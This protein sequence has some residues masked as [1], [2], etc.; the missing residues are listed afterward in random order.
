MGVVDPGSRLVAPEGVRRAVGRLVGE[1][2]LERA[3]PEVKP[4]LVPRRLV[5]LV[6]FAVGD[7]ERA[8]V[9]A[10]HVG[11]AA[12]RAVPA[13]EQLPVAGLGRGLRVR[14][15]LALLHGQRGDR[16]PLEHRQLSGVLRR[17]L[18]HLHTAGTGPDHAHPAPGERHALLRPAGRVVAVAGVPIESWQVGD[19]RL[20]TKAGAHHE[21]PRVVASAV[22]GGE[23]PPPLVVVEAR[24]SDPC[25]EIDVPAEVEH[26]IDVLEVADELVAARKPL[27]PDPIPPH[28]L[29]RVLVVGNVGVDPG[30]PVAVRP[31]DATEAG[32]RLDETHREALLPESWSW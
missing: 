24:R 20:R 26:S 15:E 10:A 7:V 16:R 5:D 22:V 3:D 1:D 23:V 18:H 14:V 25:L 11:E 6:S 12:G 21:P 19:V 2:V 27:G 30:P 31:P 13:L 17:F 28:R 32:A 29:D 8:D 9:E 4:A